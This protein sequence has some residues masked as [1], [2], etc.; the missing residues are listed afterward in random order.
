MI[1]NSYIWLK[2]NF[3]KILKQIVSEKTMGK[4]SGKIFLLKQFLVI[5]T[6]SCKMAKHTLKILWCEHRNVFKV[7]LAILQHYARK[8]QTKNSSF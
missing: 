4:R 3:V 5:L 7:C 8:G 6:L 1:E 2:R